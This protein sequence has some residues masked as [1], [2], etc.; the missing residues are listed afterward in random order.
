MEPSKPVRILRR[1]EV[2]ARTGYSNPTL[3]RRIR[4]GLFPRPRKLGLRAVGWLEEEV[5]AALR[6]LPVAETS[7]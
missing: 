3:H 4:D 6:S 1:P 2:L 7:A 5:D